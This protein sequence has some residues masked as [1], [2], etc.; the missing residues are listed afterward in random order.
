M[1]RQR[2]RKNNSRALSGELS[3][4]ADE[5]RKRYGEGSLR[6][7]SE[8]KQ[9]DRISTGVFVMDLA[10]LGGIPLN[11]QSLLAGKRHAGK[12]MMCAKIIR[13]AQ[14]QMP[15]QR[16]VYVD[17]EGTFDE[18]WNRTL[19]VD[20]ERLL[21]ADAETGEM[22]VDIADATIA[23]METSLLV[24]DSIAALAPT[25]EVEGSAEDVNVGIHAKLVT[26]MVRKI[27]A[28]LVR[29]RARG[30]YVTVLYVN[31]FRSNIGGW[32]PFGQE[33][34]S[35]PGGKALEYATSLNIDI[36]N[37]ENKGKNKES[38]DSIVTSEH[39]YSITKNKMCQGPR[40]GEFML[41]RDDDVIPGCVTGD[42]DNASTMLT[43]AK[44]FN[45]YT[46]GGQA[47]FLEFDDVKIKFGKQ[48]QC[49][50]AIREDKAL[51][52]H[53]WFWLIAHQASSLNMPDEF[54]KRIIKM[55]RFYANG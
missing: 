13:G 25:K 9:P 31:Q 55:R 15:D 36:K 1:A 22:A 38:V 53:L 21:V 3:D 50:Q 43:Y 37:K 20:T 40:T 8:V 33:A 7:A 2:A 39:P 47:Q 34:L 52:A 6:T 35:M 16:V 10:T 18:V 23:S 19:G 24:I 27:T 42:I 11:R 4:T 41:V 32:A 44:K 28:S 5:I 46:G 45:Y 48:D 51:E 17:A 29:E 49:L 26:G 30:H 54:V 14:H 12:S